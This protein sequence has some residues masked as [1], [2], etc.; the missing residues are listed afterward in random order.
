LS[1]TPLTGKHPRLDARGLEC[2]VP[3]LPL[4]DRQG[5]F[6]YVDVMHDV[7]VPERVDG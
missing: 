1:R 7:A 2:F 4:H 6:M 5:E 3:D